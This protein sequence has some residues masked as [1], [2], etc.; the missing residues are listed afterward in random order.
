[1]VVAASLLIPPSL[2]V[3]ALLLGKDGV[4]IRAVSEADDVRCPI[5]G[6]PS[7]RVHSRYERTVADLPWARCAGSSATTHLPAAD[8]RR[9][10]G[11]D[12]R[13][14]RPPHRPPA[15]PADGPGAGLRRGGRGASGRQAWDA[16]QP[17]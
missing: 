9:A 17:R 13:G 8:L 12:C 16:D 2:H 5:C 11:G 4:T 10:A 6:E 1:M 3:D 14:V 7:D 15:R